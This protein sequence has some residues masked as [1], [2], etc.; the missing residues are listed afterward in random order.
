MAGDPDNGGLVLR[1]YQETAVEFIRGRKRAALFLDMGLGKTAIVLRALTPEMLPVIV[2]APKRVA[3]NTWLEEVEKW[4]P[5]LT[6]SVAAGS[7]AK[8]RKAL[9][10]SSDII[11]ISRDNLADAVEHADKFRTFVMDEMS[12]FKNRAS[13][14]WRNAKKVTRGRGVKY[15]WGLTG[16]P[17]PNSFLELW[18]QMY[19]LD[20]GEALGTTLGGFRERYFTAGH[21]MP[22]GIITE[23]HAKPGAHK[24][25][26]MLLEPSCLSMGTEGRVA[27]PPVTYNYI[28]IPLEEKQARVYHELKKNLVV[29]LDIIGDSIRSASSAAVLGGKLRQIAAGI[30]Y[31]D[32]ADLKG[33]EYHV[34]SNQRVKKVQEIVDTATSP[35]MVFYQYR[36]EFEQLQKALGKNAHTMDEPNI[37]KRWNAGEIPILL[38]HPASAGHGLNLQFGGHTL[39]WSSLTWNLEEYQQANKR[40]ARS[41]QKN[42]VVIH[43]LIAPG[44]IDEAV[45]KALEGKDSLQKSLLDYLESPV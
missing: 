6:I 32:D 28:E 18:P 35:V 43:H 38:A 12:S 13:Q 8:R 14:R 30:S 16:T 15:I 41:G 34:L 10:S 11:V 17:S 2:T 19:L 37:V 3:E 22:N 21:S 23:W 39:V 24:R 5:D 42:P 7:P 25:I 29:D 33:G 27:L 45:V 26:M 31:V 4:R 1:D 44:T 36:A 9:E 20:G 40:L